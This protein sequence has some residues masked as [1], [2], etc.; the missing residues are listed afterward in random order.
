M[1]NGEIHGWYTS[2]FGAPP[3]LISDLLSDLGTNCESVV[4]DP[5]CG[6]G[7]TN[8]E[9]KSNLICSIGTDVN[10][11]S[12]LA[13]RAKTTWDLNPDTVAAI[14]KSVIARSRRSYS[15]LMNGKPEGALTLRQLYDT[16]LGSD[17]TLRYL[18]DYGMLERGWI[19]LVPLAQ[20]L[21]MKRTIRRGEIPE[22]YQ[23][24]FLLA[25]LSVCLDVSNIRFGPELYCSP[26]KKIPNA[27][28]QFSRSVAS[29]T[30][31]LQLPSKRQIETVSYI[32]S[33][34]ARDLTALTNSDELPKPDVV[35]TSPPYPTEHDYTRN[36]R[37]EL[38]FLEAV[39]DIESLRRIKKTMIRSNSKSIYRD[40][41]DGERVKHI[42]SIRKLV[43]RI[44]RE[45][46][47]KE[48]AFAKMYPLI[49]S[50]YF[51]GMLRHFRALSGCLEK[52]AKC[53]Y[54]V[55]DQSSYL[56]VYIPTAD[57]MSE[58]IQ[59]ADIGFHVDRIVTIRDRRGT[60]GSRRK[61]A[62]RVLFFS[63]RR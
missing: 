58:V 48:Y 10:P 1:L 52:G 3:G 27:F 19:S 49:V 63:K 14:G 9:C 26:K 32:L 6:T 2:V 23:S 57:L 55:G 25:L 4:F 38:A 39:T 15:R 31:H 54:I 7:T 45:A 21:V 17:P 24:L 50:E 42:A 18:Y 35:I 33:D 29:M 30:E 43:A 5:F 40:D 22:P 41:D 8:V 53:A 13:S 16:A 61:I 11:V 28:E 46:R 34:D 37:L 60:T 56:S 44:R 47:N 59:S 62:E 12:L 51:G 20:T 36:S